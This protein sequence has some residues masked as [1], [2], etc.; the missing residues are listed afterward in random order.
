MGFMIKYCYTGFT[1]NNNNNNN[2]N[3]NKPRIFYRGDYY[4]YELFSGGSSI[5]SVRIQN[6]NAKITILKSING[7]LEVNKQQQKAQ[8]THKARKSSKC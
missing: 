5:K 8:C 2:N 4:H 6:S 7:I 1:C 3:N